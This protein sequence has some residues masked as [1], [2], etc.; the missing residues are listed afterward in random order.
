M[1]LVHA[2]GNTRVTAGLAIDHMKELMRQST[3]AFLGQPSFSQVCNACIECITENKV[4][5][6]SSA[7]E[8]FGRRIKNGDCKKS[9]ENQVSMV[10]LL[11][12]S[13]LT[14]N[15]FSNQG[16]TFNADAFAS[17]KT[18]RIVI[19]ALWCL[20]IAFIYAKETALSVFDIG[21]LTSSI[22]ENIDLSIDSG[23]AKSV[24]TLFANFASSEEGRNTLIRSVELETIFSIISSYEQTCKQ[25][26]QH[27]LHNMFRFKIISGDEEEEEEEISILTQ[28][29]SL[30]LQLQDKKFILNCLSIAGSNT[31]NFKS[32]VSQVPGVINFAK[33]NVK[34]NNSKESIETCAAC[35]RFLGQL[36]AVDVNI[37]FNIFNQMFEL[38]NNGAQFSF[39]DLASAVC[40]AISRSNIDVKQAFETGFVDQLFNLSEGFSY[41]CKKY[42]IICLSIIACECGNPEGEQNEFGEYLLQKEIIQLIAPFARTTEKP[43]TQELVL[44]AII[45]LASANEAY[46]YLG[47]PI[48]DIAE[49]DDE[50]VALIAQTFIDQ[51]DE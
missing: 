33:E 48:E 8:E 46:D 9:N 40:W 6:A 31:P 37:G 7:L 49:T 2:S 28:M 35:I 18:A 17:V 30:L 26:V 51:L 1:E 10:V 11:C 32:I 22:I 44:S 25:E 45:A 23:V 5:E 16:I 34:L 43:R 3:Q 19:D 36:R 29:F 24:L 14:N 13:L 50:K 4:E 20:S 41:E 12:C 47:D 27:L 15:S 39:N 21:V 42:S 38:I